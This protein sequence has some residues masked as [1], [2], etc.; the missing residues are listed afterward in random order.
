MIPLNLGMR[1][2]D[3]TAHTKEEL[4][5]KLHH[6]DLGHIQLAVK[7]SFPELAPSLSTVT[8]GTAAYLGD[9]LQNNGLHISVLGCY[10]NISSLDEKIRQ[11][12]V[13]SFIH[14]LTLAKD[15]HCT[16]V[17]TET[18]SL[19]TGYITDNFT[20]EA[21]IRA[22][23][24]ILKMVEAAEKLGVLVGIEAG[25]NHPLYT[26]EL[27]K[28]LVDEVASPNLKIIFDAANLVRPDNFKDQVKNTYN[29]INA[30]QDHIA[31]VHLKDYVMEDNHVKIVPVGTGKM[32]YTDILKFIKYDR[33]LMFASLEAVREDHLIQSQKFI[34]EKYTEI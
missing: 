17:G 19:K 27:A 12:A 14:H 9:Y 13:N 24:S 3:L 2:H 23:A 8:H 33:P 25:L 34:T 16:L 32:D 20:E 11:E 18:G 29:A 6:Y 30:L 7:K 4:V 22:R 15:F 5:E 10:V 1:A 31:A 21:Y 28:R 26:F